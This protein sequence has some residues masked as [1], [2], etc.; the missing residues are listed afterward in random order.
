MADLAFAP[1]TDLAEMIRTRELSPVELMRS[2]L[3]R[4]DQLNGQ[5]NAIVSLDA[6]Q[7]EAEAAACAARL[8]S[9]DSVGPL[10]EIGRAH[11]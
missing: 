9:G 3:D 6:E 11:V 1:V 10:A 5:L 7:A 2:T 8:A 4:I